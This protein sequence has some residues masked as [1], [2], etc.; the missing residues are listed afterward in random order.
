MESGAFPDVVLFSVKKE[1]F[2]NFHRPSPSETAN[3]MES[4]VTMGVVK[5]HVSSQN[6]ETVDK[7]LFENNLQML[8]KTPV[9][10]I[11]HCLDRT[12]SNN[13]KYQLYPCT[14]QELGEAADDAFLIE[15]IFNPDYTGEVNERNKHIPCG[16]RMNFME[17]KVGALKDNTDNNTVEI[18]NKS[19]DNAE[20]KSIVT[21]VLYIPSIERFFCPLLQKQTPRLDA[22]ANA[23]GDWSR[24]HPYYKVFDPCMAAS[25]RIVRTTGHPS[26]GG[27]L[28]QFTKVYRIQVSPKDGS[29]KTKEIL[30]AH[31]WQ[32]HQ[33]IIVPDVYAKMHY[34]FYPN[35]GKNYLGAKKFYID[36]LEK[37]QSN[38]T[39]CRKY[40]EHSYYKNPRQCFEDAYVIDS[41]TITKDQQI[42]L[43]VVVH[44]SDTNHVD[45]QA[46][47]RVQRL[48]DS[49]EW[50]R[51]RAA[52]LNFASCLQDGKRKHPV[53]HQP[54]T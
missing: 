36:L 1:I 6:D 49:P 13:K 20:E 18:Y 39:G 8:A 34:R 15:G 17:G 33:V 37:S 32:D 50:D 42:L 44:S 46:T 43:R 5:T 41:S 29:M 9:W 28:K 4:D 40:V 38:K 26:M 24:N 12:M 27:F 47:I 7:R 51:C 54:L 45:E 30:T 19:N 48:C 23:A 25:L 14:I 21:V 3:T 10:V 52:C 16:P 2:E 53:R 22:F 11:A 31:H 35:P